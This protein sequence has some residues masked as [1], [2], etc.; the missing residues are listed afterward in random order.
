MR[1]EGRKKN[2]NKNLMGKFVRCKSKSSGKGRLL[3]ALTHGTYDGLHAHSYKHNTQV[4]PH[5][6]APS[7]CTCTRIS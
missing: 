2:G 3:Y 6:Y 4:S 1:L 5:A 7:V